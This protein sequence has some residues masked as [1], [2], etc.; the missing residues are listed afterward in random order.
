MTL[1][2]DYKLLVF[3]IDSNL[4]TINHFSSL[5]SPESLA[6][7]SVCGLLLLQQS[8]SSSLLHST[9]LTKG[10]FYVMYCLCLVSPTT[11][12]R[13]NPTTTTQSPPISSTEYLHFLYG[14]LATWSQVS[15]FS[16]SFSTTPLSI[17]RHRRLVA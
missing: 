13:Y 9:I 8:F 10:C 4:F 7:N 1:G 12:V 6:L 16:T 17:A 2:F 3:S 14:S 15:I 11:L 5:F